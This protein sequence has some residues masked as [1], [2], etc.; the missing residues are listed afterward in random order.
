MHRRPLDRHH[1]RRLSRAQLRPSEAQRREGCRRE[2]IGRLA[3]RVVRHVLYRR[4][5]YNSARHYRSLGVPQHACCRTTA[6]KAMQRR[7]SD[8]G[9]TA[10]D[11]KIGGRQLRLLRIV[12]HKQSAAMSRYALSRGSPRQTIGEHTR[13]RK[14]AP[15]KETPPHM[16]TSAHLDAH[17]QKHPAPAHT[18][19]G[20][21]RTTKAAP[22][23]INR[24]HTHVTHKS[25]CCTRFNQRPYIR[26]Q[27]RIL[28]F[29]TAWHGAL[30]RS[31]RYE[32]ACPPW[33]AL[34]S[35]YAASLSPGASRQTPVAIS[36]RHRP[37]PRLRSLV[38]QHAPAQSKCS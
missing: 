19:T 14:Q 5:S 29:V 37:A 20:C 27:I 23:G 22:A 35:R 4:A 26:A 36:P 8:D 1:P 32:S 11:T 17:A 16:C 9:A 7:L 10:T 18:R 38:A 31:S 13:A 6:R 25:M 12:I 15:P 28:A 33:L 34:R 30:A 3:R 21:T 24:H 2:S